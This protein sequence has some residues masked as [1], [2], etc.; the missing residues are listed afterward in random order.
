[1]KTETSEFLTPPLCFAPP[2]VPSEGLTVCG[3]VEEPESVRAAGVRRDLEERRRD[4]RGRLSEPQAHR[5]KLLSAR[6]GLQK[7]Q[8]YRPLRT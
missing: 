3:A 2:A 7:P 5:L 1:M 6:R 8:T 4:S